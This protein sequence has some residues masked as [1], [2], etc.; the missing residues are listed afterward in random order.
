LFDPVEEPLDQI[1][2]TREVGAELNFRFGGRYGLESGNLMLV[3]SF[4]AFDPIR[5]CSDPLGG[6]HP[7]LGHQ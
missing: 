3:L 7:V 1:T 2:G 5:T 4:T 6:C